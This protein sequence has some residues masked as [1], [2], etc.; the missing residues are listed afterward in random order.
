MHLLTRAVGFALS[1]VPGCSPLGQMAGGCTIVILSTNALPIFLEPFGSIVMHDILVSLTR[2]VL[3]IDVL[4]TRA[5]FTTIRERSETNL[6]VPGVS[7]A[8]MAS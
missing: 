2:W 6:P 1:G 5:T 8:A 3:V 7:T 4:L